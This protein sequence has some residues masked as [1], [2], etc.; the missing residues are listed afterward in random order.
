MLACSDFDLDC[1]GLIFAFVWVRLSL[2]PSG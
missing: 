2:W 1:F